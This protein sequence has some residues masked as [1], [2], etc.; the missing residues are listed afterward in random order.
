MG[1]NALLGHNAALKEGAT[2]EGKRQHFC[3]HGCNLAPPLPLPYLCQTIEAHLCEA[4]ST[5]TLIS[6]LASPALAAPADLTWTAYTPAAGA[7]QHSVP[8]LPTPVFLKALVNLNRYHDARMRYEDWDILIFP[9]GSK[10][11]VREFKTA[12]HVVPDLGVSSSPNTSPLRTIK[13]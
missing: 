11:P 13:R 3:R 4:V 9:R 7:S 1:F 8:A 6:R 12:C 5:I 2:T 10:T